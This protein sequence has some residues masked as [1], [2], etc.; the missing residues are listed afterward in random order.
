VTN[1]QH[2]PW[3]LCLGQHL[4]SRKHGSGQIQVPK[5][6]F[7]TANVRV[8]CALQRSK[9]ALS[10]LCRT[11]EAL[12]PA[13]YDD[14]QKIL[15]PHDLHLP[16]T[17]LGVTGMEVLQLKVMARMLEHVRTWLQTS[18]PE[19][20]ESC[21]A[22]EDNLEQPP[23]ATAVSKVCQPSQPQGQRKA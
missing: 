22:E 16:Q 10:A 23:L 18:L 15:N 6:D 5:S 7:Q 14:L 3:D 21:Y 9:V 20:V 13:V 4:P 2:F 17:L 1:E 12:R 19:L 8:R 11:S